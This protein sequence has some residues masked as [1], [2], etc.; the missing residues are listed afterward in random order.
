MVIRQ[1]SSNQWDYLPL[2]LLG[3]EQEDMIAR[4]LERGAL[5]ICEEAG[6][7]LAVCVVLRTSP[8]VVE[9]KN[10][11]VAPAR[12]RHGIGRK[13]LLAVCGMYAEDAVELG[14]GEV[15]GTLA[16]Y[17]ACGF[18][19]VRRVRNFFTEHYDHPI[20]EEGILLRDMIYLR[21]EADTDGK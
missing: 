21:R 15:P 16:F 12:Q 9:V 18:H 17:R 19:P 5:Y 14:T 11:A 13:L 3:D 2:L 10:L 20:W 4:Y 7:T 8:H 6:E 1:I